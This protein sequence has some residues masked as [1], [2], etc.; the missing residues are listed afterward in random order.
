MTTDSATGRWLSKISITALFLL[1]VC[2][3]FAKIRA[4]GGDSPF[5]GTWTGT[6]TID[7]AHGFELRARSRRYQ[8]RISRDGKVRVLGTQGPERW[9]LVQIPF[10]L[11]EL[12]DDAVITGQ[13]EGEF[14]VESQAFNL[15]KIGDDRLLVYFWR[16]VDDIAPRADG[17]VV[18][19]MGGD[20]EF[21]RA[22]R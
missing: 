5:S 18:W 3:S 21:Q 17:S 12:G 4:Q 10:L 6:I 11:T 8:F 20:G 9:N 16:V 15:T 7:Q 2:G 22:Q 14:W 19:A 1:A 13:H